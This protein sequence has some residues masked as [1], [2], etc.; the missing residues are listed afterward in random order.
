MDHFEDALPSFRDLGEVEKRAVK[1]TQ[2]NLSFNHG[3]FVQAEAPPGAVFTKFR[4]ALIVD[5]KSTISQP[6]VA[7]YFVHWLTDLAGA[8]PTPLGGC[9]KFVTKF[10]LPV[11]NS[12][13][14][15]FEF[16]HAIAKRSE[17]EVMENYLKTRWAEHQPSAGPVPTGE[18]AIAKMRL[19]CMAQMNAMPV[20][21]AFDE[22]Q[23]EEQ[24]V[25]SVEMGRSGCMTQSYSQGVVPEEVRQAPVGPAFLVYYGPAYLQSLGNDD[26][27]MRLCILAEVYR[28]ARI[29]W[30][31]NAARTDQ[32]VTVRIDMIKALSTAEILQV[33][34]EGDV[35]L[36]VRHND[37]EAFIERSSKKKLNKMLTTAQPVQILDMTC[38]GKYH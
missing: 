18:S 23:E 13:L 38:L 17:T 22:L 27:V 7:L 5:H 26:C 11:L 29:L 24:Q 25:L 34:S 21:R 9:E 33:M 31:A 35:W 36:M 37:S 28:C 6:D 8:E 15:S 2:C 30:P 16:I 10:P 20:L 12:F 32:T 1:F 4:E 14:Q 19:L 3:W